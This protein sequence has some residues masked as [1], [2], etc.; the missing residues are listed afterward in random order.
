MSTKVTEASQS[1]VPIKA[2]LGIKELTAVLVK[3]YELHDGLYDLY[4]EYHFAAGNF[5]PSPVEMV[6]STVVGISKL[7][8]TKVLQVGPLT[9]D[10]SQTN[11]ATVTPRKKALQRSE[12]VRAT[13]A[14]R[15][16]GEPDIAKA[17]AWA[18]QGK[19][20]K[21]TVRK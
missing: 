19:S 18:R 12:A 16:L 11:P 15:N 2:P 17:V 7:G 9:V 14:E 1:P 5:G 8:L 6:P 4:L 20:A 3:H 10:A 21:R 13:I